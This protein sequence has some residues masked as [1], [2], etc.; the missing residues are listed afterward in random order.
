MV[1]NI[2]LTIFDLNN[3]NWVNNCEN[4]ILLRHPKV[5]SSYSKKYKLNSVE[6]LGYPQQYEI[7]NILK[8][9]RS[10]II[11]DSSE[12]LRKLKGTINLVYED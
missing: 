4:C 7:V 6:E 11:I 1:K 10:Y 8:I 5:I 12:L 3:I 2:W 9:N